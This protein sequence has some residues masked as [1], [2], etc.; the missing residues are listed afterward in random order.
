MS[1]N[2]HQGGMAVDTLIAIG[3]GC[4]KACSHADIIALVQSMLSTC[5]ISSARRCMFT[6]ED[7]VGDA[8][9]AAAA[10]SLKLDLI[11]LPREALEATTSRLQTKSAAAQRRFGLPSIAEAA[12]L[13]G[14]GAGGELVGPRRIGKGVTCAL[15]I[16]DA[17][18]SPA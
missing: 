7:K 1:A 16:T 3:V 17:K 15:A 14:A 11:F 5:A 6:L 13:A 2:T 8:E 12:A 18:G 10:A 4:R 9:L